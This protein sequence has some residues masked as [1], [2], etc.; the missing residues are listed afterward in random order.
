MAD[1][2][3]PKRRRRSNLRL[4]RVSPQKALL[5]LGSLTALAAPLVPTSDAQYRLMTCDCT[6]S[7][8][9]FTAGDGPITVGYAHN[10]YTVAEIKEAIENTSSISPGDKIA[11]E[12]A[13]RWVRIVGTLSG[14]G[15][16]SLNDGQRVRTRLN[17]AIQIG[18][19]VNVFIF[20]E[21]TG[22][23]TTGAILDVVG[24]LWVLDY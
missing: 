2:R 3:K 17:W 8:I 4:V 6:W 22:A 10:D 19:A 11:Q 24:D 15:A 21:S 5:T 20:N 12:K 1:K 13:S 14:A 23:L 9:N 18:S 7:L 16:S